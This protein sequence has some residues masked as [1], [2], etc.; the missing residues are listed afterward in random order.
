M[1]PSHPNFPRNRRSVLDRLSGPTPGVRYLTHKES[2]TWRERIERT[3][4]RACTP[5]KF[6]QAMGDD[7]PLPLEVV[8]ND[9]QQVV[10][11]IFRRP[12]IPAEKAD[13]VVSS[14]IAQ[15][16]GKPSESMRDPKTGALKGCFYRD[17]EA[18]R[19]SEGLKRKVLP[20]DSWYL[21]FPPEISMILPDS[22]YLRD[23]L[24]L[25]V[26]SAWSALAT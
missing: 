23:K 24:A 7:M 9:Q 19:V 15:V 25:A 2:A 13:P 6:S 11:H 10:V 16:F 17:E 14:A 5:L 26:K 20:S 4:R 12:D 18:I 22:D 3:S 21:E 8:R 1:H